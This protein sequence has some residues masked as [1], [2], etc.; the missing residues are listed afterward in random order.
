MISSAS[1]ERFV[2]FSFFALLNL[3][4]ANGASMNA[5]P[6]SASRSLDDMRAEMKSAPPNNAEYSIT[7]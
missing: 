6:M 1:A 5:P 3:Y 2:S 4:T 7:L